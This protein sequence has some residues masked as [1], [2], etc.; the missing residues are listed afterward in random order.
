MTDA[1]SSRS[2]RRWLLGGLAASAVAAAVTAHNARQVL[3]LRDEAQAHDNALVHAD[4]V[5]EGLGPALNLVVLGDSSSIGFGLAE[6][7]MAFPFLL[8]SRLAIATGRRVTVD[9]LGENG[10]QTHDVTR[11]QVARLRQLEPDV[12][13]IV[14]GVN[15]AVGRRRPAQVRRDTAVM[16]DAVT[17]AVP[18][19]H[20]VLA[21]CP[22]L[23]NSPAIPRPLNLVLG[24]ACQAVARAQ[25]STC[26]DLG[27]AARAWP[28]RAVREDFSPDGFHPG[29]VGHR[30]MA[31]HVGDT[32]LDH[33]AETEAAWTSA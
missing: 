33:L 22:D 4:A 20:I 7:R 11:T 29:V 15:D 30:K 2:S 1:T 32:L 25:L 27:I 13:A 6:P 19:A 26:Q 12:V 21:P 8:A 10:A 3:R 5:G 28:V 14:I 17:A 18:E 23:R 24:L 9:A 16:I 31:D